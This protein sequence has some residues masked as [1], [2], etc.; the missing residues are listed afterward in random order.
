MD[1]AQESHRQFYDLAV[2]AGRSKQSSQ[3]GFV[4]YC[5]EA[6]DEGSHDTIPIVDN[7]LFSLG[8]VGTRHVEAIL[9]AKSLLDKLLHFQDRSQTSQSRGNFP[10]YLH[11]YPHCKNRFTAVRLL[12][13]F[14]WLLKNFSISIGKD[15]KEKLTKSS[16][17]LLDYCTKMHKEDTVPFQMA[18]RIAAAYK[19]FGELWGDTSLR[20]RGIQLLAE[21]K[22]QSEAADFGSWFCPEYI[23]DTLVALQMAYSNSSKS[24]WSNFWQWL[25]ESYQRA[26]C[27]FLGP[28]IKTYQWRQEP[29]PTLY[30]LYLG[31]FTGAASYSSF[32]DHIYQLQGVLIQPIEEKIFEP[33]YPLIK[34]GEVAGY[35]WQLEHHSNYGLSLIQKMPLPVDLQKC[36]HPLFFTWGSKVGTQSF[37]CQGG[38]SSFIDFQVDANSFE[39]FFHLTEPVQVEDKEKSREISFFVNQHEAMTIFVGDKASNTFQLGDT[40]FFK[41][42]ELGFSLS[43]HLVEGE[44]RFFGHISPG[45]RPAQTCT[46]GENRFQCFDWHIFL[47]TVRRPS[48]CIVKAIFK[49]L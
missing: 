22:K 31:Y 24:P 3:T 20:D 16:R 47:R 11:S 48:A 33:T 39:L 49:I 41:S 12:A 23:A 40:L 1:S 18:I 17:L 25:G 32:I 30:D 6:L 28:A 46:Q 13:P 44:G 27:C 29:K 37:V 34:Q 14:Y 10:E 21:L 35:H 8:L 42:A 38:N 43:F 5:Y 15:L 4:H 45:N 9:E 26:S 7:V 36:Y 19:A 2:C